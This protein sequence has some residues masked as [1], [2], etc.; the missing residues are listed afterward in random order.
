MREERRGKK[1][2]KK[3]G[4]D[5]EKKENEGRIERERMKAGQRETGKGRYTKKG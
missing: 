4:K 5:K 1:R 2:G 3:E